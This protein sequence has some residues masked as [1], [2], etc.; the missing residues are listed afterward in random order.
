MTI[1]NVDLSHLLKAVEDRI[2]IKQRGKLGTPSKLYE[3]YEAA[4]LNY[5][6]AIKDARDFGY[7]PLYADNM[8]AWSIKAHGY[9]CAINEEESGNAP[10]VIKQ[11]ERL[12]YIYNLSALEG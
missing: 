3:P 7:T 5:A 6:E 11:R 4:L 2:A 12:D 9:E 1:S 8:L 10:W